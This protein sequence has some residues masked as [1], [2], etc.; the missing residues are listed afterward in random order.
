MPSIQHQ[1]K[2]CLLTYAQCGDLDPFAVVNLLAD[3]GAECI[4]GRESHADGGTHLHA[5]AQ[6]ET[7]FRSRGHTLFDVDGRHPNIAPVRWGSPE[8]VAE[9]AGKMGDIVAGGLDLSQIDST[10]SGNS[11][12][13]SKQSFEDWSLIVNSETEA[14]F[15]SNVTT[16]APR[17]LACNHQALLSFAK[18]KWAPIPEIYVSPY[19]EDDYDLSSF[20]EIQ[21]WREQHLRHNDVN[22]R[23]MSLVIWGPTRTGK[24]EWARCLDRHAYYNLHWNQDEPLE[25]AKFAIFD[26]LALGWKGFDFLKPWIGQQKNFTVTDK[27]RG[28]KQVKWGKPVIILTQHDPM[29][30]P[31]VDHNWLLG[32]AVIVNVN[33]SLIRQTQ[34]DLSLSWEM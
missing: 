30:S 9:Y 28:K 20:P 29:S 25:G 24:T 16:L 23:G 5:Y 3:L 34:Q 17:Q 4:I 22:V 27:Y 6:W 11:Q 8:W 2:Q 19:T 15:W 32:N 10:I 14:E 13:R 26:D 12:A 1:F 31:D 33:S 7:K 18:W 21:M